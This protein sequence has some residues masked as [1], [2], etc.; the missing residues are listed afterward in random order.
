M[1]LTVTS[2]LRR[3]SRMRMRSGCAKALKN[4]ALNSRSIFKYSNVLAGFCQAWGRWPARELAF[5][6][7]L[8]TREN[9][10]ADSKNHRKRA[11]HTLIRGQWGALFCVC[12]VARRLW[13]SKRRSIC[14]F[15]V[16]HF[17]LREATEILFAG[18]L[19]E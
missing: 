1:R 12:A 16:C 6:V 7:G 17:N 11:L 14:L 10:V 13:I 9:S 3:A 4:S 18:A 19:L 2:P 5:A 8:V 15:G